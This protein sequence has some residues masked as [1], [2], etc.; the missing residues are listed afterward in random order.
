M[1][2]RPGPRQ[3]SWN[4]G[5]ISPEAH[6]RTELKQVYSAAKSMIGCE[7]VPQGG[8]RLLP[9]TRKLGR[10]RRGL[11]VQASSGIVYTLGP[12]AA[13]ATLAVVSFAA[14]IPLAAV[15]I[16]NF[17]ANLAVNDALLVEWRHPTTG[18]W[19]AIGSAF[20]VGLEARNR[21]AAF[22]PGLGIVADQVRVRLVVAPGG[23]TTFGIVAIT[24]QGETGTADQPVRVKPFTFSSEQAYDAVF[25]PGH[26][27]F[28]RDGVFVGASVI[29]LA[30]DQVDMIVETQ[31]FDTMLVFH[32]DVAS[33]RIFRDGADHEWRVDSVPFENVPQVDLGGSYVQVTDTWQIFIRFP[34]SGDPHDNGIGLYVAVNVDGEDTPGIQVTGAPDWAAFTAAL[35]AAIENL[36]SVNPGLTSSFAVGT[37]VAVVTIGFAGAGNNGRAFA[38]SARVVNSVT[39]AA[40]ATHIQIGET[41]GESLMSVGRGWPACGAFYQDRLVTGGFKAKKG[42]IL[43]SVTGEYFDLNIKV[44]ATTGA[45]LLNLDTDGAERVQ[46]LVRGR[47]LLIFTSEAEYFISDRQVQRGQPV[48]IVECS[49]NGSAAGVPIVA[50]EGS[51]VYATKKRSLL[52]A[53]TYSDVSQAYESEPISLLASHLVTEIADMAIMRATDETD[54]ERLLLV[55]DD[56]LMVVACLI[57]NQEVGGYV[58]WLTDG[59]VKAVSVNGSNRPTLAVHR[60]VDGET[61]GFLER[62]EDELLLDCATDKTLSIGDTLVSGLEDYEGASVWAIADGFVSGPF[63]VED[64][65]ITL[66][67]PVMTTTVT[68]GR[69]TPPEMETL[70]PARDVGPRIVLQRPGRIHTVRVNVIDTTS[71]AVGANGGTPK[72]QPL[73]RAGMATDQPLAP[74]TGLVDIEG[75]PGF[76]DE[77][78]VRITQTRPGKLQVRDLVT[79]A[80][81]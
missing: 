14:P 31:R 73:Y 40:T 19:S 47:H 32:E 41:G 39:A 62:F 64:A 56:G 8:F 76:V 52:M 65:E 2:A 10:I 80:R 6:A 42:A 70:P 24:C 58:R 63:V 11:S 9:R 28:W 49:R 15:T 74:Q 27:D 26:V 72:D 34:T 78:T 59:A 46:R 16:G 21:T 81:L 43:A 38:L 1:T 51:L 3:T 13:P 20:D 12:H 29:G 25:T 79:E 66:P 45:I 67:H 75:L 23:A 53:A 18:V 30:S 36:P 54:A 57:R 33:L 17:Y 44:Q 37:G 71:I 7:P 60:E 35:L 61:I 77:P 68:V 50:S 48:N 22:Q 5:E 55:R 69:W 4:Q